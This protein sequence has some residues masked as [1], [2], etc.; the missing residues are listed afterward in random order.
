[1]QDLEEDEATYGQEEVDHLVE[2]TLTQ[3]TRV[4]TRKKAQQQSK[5]EEKTLERPTKKQE[6]K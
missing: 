1:M 2:K 4:L 6:G 3:S 5:E